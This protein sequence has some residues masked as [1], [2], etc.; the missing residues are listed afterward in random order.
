MSKRHRR[1][2]FDGILGHRIAPPHGRSAKLSKV[3]ASPKVPPEHFHC[4]LGP[5][6]NEDTT[7]I[8]PNCENDNSSAKLDIADAITKEIDMTWAIIAVI[9]I[10][11]RDS[12]DD[13]Y[14]QGGLRLAHAHLDG[15]CAILEE[16]N[17]VL[18]SE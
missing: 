6:P 17:R 7:K 8:V 11:L 18:Q 14:A 1:Q 13:K 4:A 16:V 2:P 15:L 9:E 10:L 3:E 5:L 12:G